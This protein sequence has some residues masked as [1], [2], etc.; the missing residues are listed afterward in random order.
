[1]ASIVE[2]LSANLEALLQTEVAAALSEEMISEAEDL[3]SKAG[4]LS[5]EENYQLM[6]DLNA[7]VKKIKAVAAG[8]KEAMA[9]LQKVYDAANAAMETDEYANDEN[10]TI[11]VDDI[12]EWQAQ[13]LEKVE[14]GT[15]TDEERAEIMEKADEY[16]ARLGIRG[17]WTKAT[18]EA[19]VEMTSLIVNADFSTGN[20]N[21]WTDT[22]TEG[23]HGF[24]SNAV[25]GDNTS[26]DGAYCD[27]F[28]E[29]WR[30]G[31]A[32]LGDNPV[33]LRGRHR[34]GQGLGRH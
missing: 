26:E 10:Y 9:E 25:Y 32:A 34:Q 21:G 1:M 17:D 14:L 15:L 4:N 23:N 8:N 28:V 27:K 30:A 7:M 29:A 3:I 33:F 16:V 19:P 18:E 12:A 2:S 6:K 5:G 24:Q 13:M 22:F 31:S 11:I 20:I